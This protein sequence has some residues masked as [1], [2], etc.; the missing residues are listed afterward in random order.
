[1]RQVCQTSTRELQQ[2][3]TLPQDA[4]L[5]FDPAHEEQ[6]LGSASEGAASHVLKTSKRTVVSLQE[7]R[8]Q[9]REIVRQQPCDDS[10]RSSLIQRSMQLAGLVPPSARYGF[11]LIAHVGIESYL[12]G[13]SLKEIRRDLADRSS[14]IDIPASS[15]WDQ[16]QKFLFCLGHLHQ[17]AA[18]SIRQYLAEQG[19]VTWLLDGTVEPG[20]PVFLGIEDASSGMILGGWKIISGR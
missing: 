6:D 19:K 20:S 12:R 9:A 15:L 2:Q 13:H 8:F 7:G 14:S 10:E 5:D 11:D 18:N 17:Q 16:Q 1:M 4:R 3:A